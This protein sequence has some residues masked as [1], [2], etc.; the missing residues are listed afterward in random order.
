MQRISGYGM[1][2]QLSLSAL[3]DELAQVRTRKKNSYRKLSVLFRGE[4]GSHSFGRTTTKESA[5]PSST[6]NKDK[7]RDPDAH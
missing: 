5:A 3:N 4:S 6:K 1:D 2:K 7:Q